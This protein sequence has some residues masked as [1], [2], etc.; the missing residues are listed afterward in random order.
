MRARPLEAF[1]ER[2]ER[3]K[4]KLLD[5]TIKGSSPKK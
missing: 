3:K 5:E 4:G 2:Y 1:G